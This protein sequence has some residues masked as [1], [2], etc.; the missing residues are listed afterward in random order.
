MTAPTLAE[1]RANAAL[2][3]LEAFGN[4]DGA[5]GVED[6]KAWLAGSA[7]FLAKR[8]GPAVAS[9]LVY[10]E[11]DGIIAKAA[12]EIAVPPIKS[13]PARY[14]DSWLILPLGL[15]VGLIVASATWLVRP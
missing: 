13:K 10:R 12:A 3:T 4:S 6:A 8:L 11:A 2:R 7:A 5:G 9:E 14:S 1:A 15:A